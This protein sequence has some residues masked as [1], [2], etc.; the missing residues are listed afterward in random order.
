MRVFLSELFFE[1]K[2]NKGS[3]IGVV[4]IIL[5]VLVA[6]LAPVLAPHDPTHINAEFLKLPPSF[7]EGGNA[8]FPLGT[9]DLGR[10]L[11]S[12]LIYGSQVSLSVGFAV[13][14]LSLITGTFLGVVAGYFGGWV[15]KTIMRLTDLI[16]S[17]PS[18][19]F[20][21]VIVAV[22]GPG[23]S[24]AIIAVSI[25][26]VPNF[27]RIIRAQVMVEKNRQ[28]VH[29]AKLFGA[30]HMR[31]MFVEILP[32]CMAPLIV[33][34][35][36]G[37]SDGILNCAALGFLGLGAQAPMSEWGTMLS[38]AR[39]YIESS[40]WMVTLPGLCILVIV[41]SFNLLGDGLRDALD[42]RL[43]KQN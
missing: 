13:V 23:I 17:L 30:S 9:D 16:M 2:K 39:S 18:I 38:D 15:D 31:I 32:N 11:L 42:P 6:L 40:P 22:L 25:V 19:L 7:A 37:F 5:S 29:A 1:L 12:R 24:N 10:D 3:M 34:A 8:L 35:S 43:K 33:Q 4:I 21:I 14:V 27:V 20:A 36:L 41:L 26:A 28:Y